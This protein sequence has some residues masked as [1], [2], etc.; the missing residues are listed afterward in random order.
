M[1]DGGES[2]RRFSRLPGFRRMAQAGRPLFRVT[3]GGGARPRGGE[4]ILTDRDSDASVLTH[5]LGPAAS[6]SLPSACEPASRDIR[7]FT[8]VF[9]GLLHGHDDVEVPWVNSALG[10]RFRGRK[11]PTSCTVLG[12]MS[13]TCRRSGRRA[14]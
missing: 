4:G 14:L 5:R 9:D 1:G 7:A 6:V 12:A 10:N 8:P 13:T 2:Y 11:T 3:A